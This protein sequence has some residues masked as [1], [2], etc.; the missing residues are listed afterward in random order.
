FSESEIELLKTFS[1][2]AVITIENVRLF[3]ELEA[4]NRDLTEALEQ[5]TA[6]AEV[7][8]VIGSSPTDTQ[9]VFDAIVNSA[10]R[11]SAAFPAWCTAGWATRCIS[12]LL[13]R[14]LHRARQRS[15][16]SILGRLPSS[17][18]LVRRSGRGPSSCRATSKPINGCQRR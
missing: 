14:R 18:A 8:R 7:L 10:R 16:I 1:D 12:P 9:P 6:T 2:Q 5:Q 17:R 11:L 15:G 13:R 4:R 3:R